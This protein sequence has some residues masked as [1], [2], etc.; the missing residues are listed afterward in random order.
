M[1]WRT[2]WGN[3]EDHL[4]IRVL[5]IRIPVF[6][7]RLFVERFNCVSFVKEIF[8]FWTSLIGV[9]RFLLIFI[10]SFSCWFVCR[11]YN[12]ADVTKTSS[13]PVANKAIF[14]AVEYQTSINTDQWRTF[15]PI[16]C[17]LFEIQLNKFKIWNINHQHTPNPSCLPQA[18]SRGELAFSIN[19]IHK[20]NLL[21]YY[22]YIIYSI[23]LNKGR[24]FCILHL[25]QIMHKI[26]SLFLRKS[27]CPAS[28]G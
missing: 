14:R 24:R 5:G 13:Y 22:H 6:S 17:S 4:T 7:T 23:Y 8:A 3:F 1:Q 9:D 18:G 21:L 10:A 12:F 27:L 25:T 16:P 20:K 2:V 15:L 19:F 26:P 28:P 11:R